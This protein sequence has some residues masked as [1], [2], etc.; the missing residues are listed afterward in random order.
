[1]RKIDWLI[2]SGFGEGEEYAQSYE[3]QIKNPM[4]PVRC[5]PTTGN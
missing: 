2:C 1:M 5:K 3:L 4:M